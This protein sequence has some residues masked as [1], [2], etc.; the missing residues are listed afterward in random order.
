MLA[1]I[2]RL[3]RRGEPTPGQRAAE[4]ALGR[5]EAALEEAEA[6]RPLV[7]AVA[8]HLRAQRSANH[9]AERIKAALEGG[10]Q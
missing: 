5:A 7:E 3:A 6:R 9:F 10:A 1:W 2:R 4:G 8:A